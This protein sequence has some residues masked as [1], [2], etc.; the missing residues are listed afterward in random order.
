[1][2]LAF[3]DGQ[4]EHETRDEHHIGITQV[5]TGHPF[6]RDDSQDGKDHQREEGRHGEG[7]DLHDPVATHQED[8]VTASGGG[9]EEEERA[10]EKRSYED[11]KSFE[12]DSKERGASCHR[13]WET[14]RERTRGDRSLFCMQ[15]SRPIMRGTE[16]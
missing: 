5:G 6:Y 3:F 16:Y 14:G 15:S 12:V 2:K 4:T 1:M 10:E 13:W 9:A 11:P 7:D 8:T